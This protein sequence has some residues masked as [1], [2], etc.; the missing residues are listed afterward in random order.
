[1]L[2]IMNCWCLRFCLYLLVTRERLRASIRRIDP[3][4][5]IARRPSERT[6]HRVY[7]VG[8]PNHLWHFD[9][10]HKLIAWR[11]VIHGCIDGFTRRFIYLQARDNNKATTVLDI[12]EKAVTDHG[13]PHR[14]RSDR[15]GEN[16]G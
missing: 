7:N 3:A 13:W 14:A 2:D 12:F 8:G 4:G 11:I 5:R 6:P 9:G 16:V 1:M 10:N 15:G